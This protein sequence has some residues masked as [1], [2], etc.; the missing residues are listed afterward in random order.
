MFKKL[1]YWLA[2]SDSRI[3][4]RVP[5]KIRMQHTL[6]GSTVLVTACF[7][8]AAGSFLF[9]SVFDSLI[10]A[11]LLGFLYC[12]A[13]VNIDRSIVAAENRKAAFFRIPLAV[14]IGLLVAIPLEIKFFEDRIDEKISETVNTK[15]EA[16]FKKLDSINAGFSERK[17]S[18]LKEISALKS[19]IAKYGS[20]M[21]AEAVGRVI[22]GRTG[23]AGMGLAYNAA[24][25]QRKNS[26]RMLEKAQ[27]EL[28]SLDS[29]KSTDIAFFKDNTVRPQQKTYDLLSRYEALELVKDESFSAWFIATLIRLFFILIEILPALFKIFKENERRENEYD[30]LLNARTEVNLQH[31]NTKANSIMEKIPELIEEDKLIPSLTLH[32]ASNPMDD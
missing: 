4:E 17:L 13:I 28:L 9:Y 6:M 2:V 24:A 3:L 31:I 10:I 29:L 18:L 7:A 20:Y 5:P 22:A 16:Y 11:M 26:E 14:V 32:F 8:Y 12:F 30:A 15:N 25:E 21:E 1:F 19:E 23:Q 27:T